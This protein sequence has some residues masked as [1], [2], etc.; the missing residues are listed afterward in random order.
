MFYPDKMSRHQKEVWA[1][2][3]YFKCPVNDGTRGRSGC[4]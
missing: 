3:L 1:I 2:G 4:G